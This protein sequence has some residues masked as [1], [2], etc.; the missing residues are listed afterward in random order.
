M[1][2]EPSPAERVYR[3][4]KKSGID[5]VASVPCVNL[6]E[7]LELISSDPEILHIAVTR[8]EEG[9]GICAGA[10]IGGKRPAIAMQNSGLG[11]CINALASLDML[12]GIPLLMLISH[13]GTEGEKLVGQLPMGRLTEPLLESMGIPSMRPRPVEV[14]KI[15]KN[16]WIQSESKRVPVA[17]LLD[18]PFWEG[19]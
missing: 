5:L 10:Y 11:N 1:K 7:L 9:V 14:E 13:R 15:I 2:S 8:E 12:Y 19:R 17:V 16:A 4:I 18:I 6:E 3:G